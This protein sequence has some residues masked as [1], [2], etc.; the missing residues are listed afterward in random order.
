MGVMTTW[1]SALPVLLPVTAQLLF[2]AVPGSCWGLW[3]AA[4]VRCV[5][6]KRLLRPPAMLLLWLSALPFLEKLAWW[7]LA[8]QL[9]GLGLCAVGV[10]VAAQDPRGE[11]Q[12]PVE[13]AE[14]DADK[15]KARRHAEKSL[16][17]SWGGLLAAWLLSI[18]SLLP[19]SWPLAVSALPGLALG[20]F[21]VRRVATQGAP[22]QIREFYIIHATFAWLWNLPVLVVK[23]SWWIFLSLEVLVFTTCTATMSRDTDVVSRLRGGRNYCVDFT[24]LFMGVPLPVLALWASADWEAPWTCDHAPGPICKTWPLPALLAPFLAAATTF[25]VEFVSL[26]GRDLFHLKRGDLLARALVLVVL[27]AAPVACMWDLESATSSVEVPDLN[28]LDYTHVTN[29]TGIW[30]LSSL[31]L[32]MRAG[33][34]LRKMPEPVWPNATELLHPPPHRADFWVSWMLT[35]SGLVVFSAALLLRFACGAASRTS[36]T[37]QEPQP[38]GAE[39]ELEQATGSDDEA[40]LSDESLDMLAWV[41]VP[42]W[43]VLCTK[44]A[45]SAGNA[46][47]LAAGT[48]LPWEAYDL[49]LTCGLALFLAQ[50]RSSLRKGEAFDSLQ[51]AIAPPRNT[52][53]QAEHRYGENYRLRGAIFGVSNLCGF[54]YGPGFG[55]GIRKAGTVLGDAWPAMSRLTFPAQALVLRALGC[56]SYGAADVAV[57]SLSLVP[58]LGEAFDSLK[59]SVLAAQAIASDTG[60]VRPIGWGALGYLWLLHIAILL[61]DMSSRLELCRGY[62]TL[63]FLKS[64]MG[65]GIEDGFWKKLRQKLL[66]LCYKQSTPTRRW[67]MLLEDAPQGIIASVIS[68]AD[69]L[70]PFTLVVNLII[71]FVR[72]L[73]AWLFHDHVAWEVRDWLKNEV[74][75]AYAAGVAQ[76]R[77]WGG[78]ILDLRELLRTLMLARSDE[79]NSWLQ[80]GPPGRCEALQL[81]LRF[82]S[83]LGRELRELSEARLAALQAPPGRLPRRVVLDLK[84]CDLGDEECRVLCE[85]LWQIAGGCE[86]LELGLWDNAITAKGVEFLAQGLGEMKAL[87]KLEL[88]LSNNPKLGDAGCQALC[89]SLRG[90]LELRTLELKL[91]YTGL[92]VEG[93]AAL[94]ALGE[95]RLQELRGFSRMYTRQGRGCRGVSFISHIGKELLAIILD[96]RDIPGPNIP[97]QELTLLIQS[98]RIPPEA[99][100]ELRGVWEL[101]RQLRNHIPKLEIRDEEQLK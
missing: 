56:S 14:E 96:S 90:M 58:F 54:W 38:Q 92:G 64:N 2:Q 69:G 62:L 20:L 99:L 26:H 34:W 59:D 12:E 83:E 10:A 47:E 28:L 78:T 80:K 74:L 52:L 29:Y 24:R 41:L 89:R 50:A 93:C 27:A 18:G 53:T 91:W 5:S 51:S 88:H 7:Q 87:T 9:P 100:E 76:E 22:P 95:L 66:Q 11:G 82:D 31:R 23:G 86:E 68:V 49:L 3:I 73:L 75:D 35:K 98:N 46:G 71:P 16:A 37:G 33:Q 36:P 43:L 70:K 55:E 72:L 61:P 45:L 65:L 6:D 15:R 44:V 77:G 94:A 101:R 85:S 4:H 8:L 30:S 67:S 32:K 17:W 19:V 57:A 13:E 21:L 48:G 42:C 60:W 40:A 79:W 97:L 1:L 84:S 25:S 81:D 39:A 63:F